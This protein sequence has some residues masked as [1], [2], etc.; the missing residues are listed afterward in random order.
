M[1]NKGKVVASYTYDA[2]GA[3]KI[4]SD[5]TGIIARINPFRYRGYCFDQEIG[6]YYLQSRYYDACVGR[7]ISGDSKI[8]VNLGIQSYALYCYCANSP[9]LRIDTSGCAWWHVLVNVVSTVVAVAVVVVAVAHIVN[10]AVSLSQAD[11]NKSHDTKNIVYDQNKIDMK[12]G[13]ETFA[14]MG[15]GAAATHNAIILAGGSSSLADVVEF[16]QA[17]DLTLGFAGVYFTNIQLYLKRK[18]YSNK[19]YLTRLKNN[20]DKNIKNCTRKI[21]ILAYKHS[22]GGHYI[23]IQYNK[24]DEKFHIYNGNNNNPVKSVDAWIKNSKS[25]SPLCLITI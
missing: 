14:A 24:N 3:C 21:A 7:F 17:H 25:R 22:S 15:C 13:C 9:V 5:S 19:I 23:A 16:M 10:A 4:V 2:W 1:H 6:L 18:G 11:Y 8:G 20:I 12:L